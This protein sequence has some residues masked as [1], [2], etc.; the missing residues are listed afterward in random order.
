MRK[1]E[2][3]QVVRIVLILVFF[4]LMTTIVAWVENVLVAMIGVIGGYQ[5]MIYRGFCENIITMTVRCFMDLMI[6]LE[7][8]S[9]HS[10]THQKK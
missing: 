7:V 2:K 3:E 4:R 5:K 8:T 9:W 6:F 1:L 10:A